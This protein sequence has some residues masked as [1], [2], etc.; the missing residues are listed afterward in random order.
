MEVKHLQLLC[1][2]L[3]SI[4]TIPAVL[5]ATVEIP[6]IPQFPSVNVRQV[7]YG[8]FFEALPLPSNE[9]YFIGCIKGE[10]V[11]LQC[12]GE[13]IFDPTVR[14]C[15]DKIVDTT[16][17]IPSTTTSEIPTTTPGFN[18]LCRG[19]N[20]VFINHPTDCGFA[21]YCH[22]EVAYLRECPEN[23]IFDISISQC[24]GGNRDTCE[25]YETTTPPDFNRLCDGLDRVF[26][27]HPTNCQSAFFC[28]NGIAIESRCRENTIF[29]IVINNCREGNPETCEFHE[30][31]TI[32]PDFDGLCEG[33][34]DQFINHPTNCAK[35][36]F[37]HNNRAFLREC[38]GG[39]IFDLTSSICR[40]GNR[41]TCDFYD[42]DTIIQPTQIEDN[43]KG[44]CKGQHFNYIK[45]PHECD[46]AIFCYNGYPILKECPLNN[47][48]DIS[49]ESCIERNRETCKFKLEEKASCTEDFLPHET[50]KSRYYRCKSGVAYSMIC[51]QNQVFDISLSTCVNL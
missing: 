50:D 8:L 24:R 48:F 47:V 20:N 21:I 38:N 31:T 10:G 35:A 13:Q 14:T 42:A 18:Y 12:N 39:S 6:V 2:L 37:C 33:V 43:L 51:E 11:I 26:V 30:T 27:E 25:F 36:I 17:E 7:C 4:S 44:L 9:K 23:T 45:H 15:I 34:V 28:L 29:D 49:T 32:A 40:P 16:T 41:E 46:K 19:L 1:I 22:N 5:C 3:I